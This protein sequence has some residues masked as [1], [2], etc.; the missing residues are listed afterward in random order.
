MRNETKL[1]FVLMGILAV[2][3]AVIAILLSGVEITGVEIHK[4]I[5][6]G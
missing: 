1:I 4:G 2:A 5:H 6:F 3:A